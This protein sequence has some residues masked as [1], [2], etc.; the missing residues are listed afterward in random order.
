MLPDNVI[1]HRTDADH[2]K[3]LAV[4]TEFVIWTPWAGYSPSST[5]NDQHQPASSLATAM[6]ATTDRFLR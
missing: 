3:T 4:T 1:A 5:A 2:S 6:L